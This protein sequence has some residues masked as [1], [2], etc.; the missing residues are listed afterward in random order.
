MAKDNDELPQPL[1]LSGPDVILLKRLEHA[2][3]GNPCNV[4]NADG[5]QHDNW[6]NEVVQ[7]IQEEV[8][9]S[10]QEAV[11]EIHPRDPFRG[12]QPDSESSRRRSPPQVEVHDGDQ[13]DC[14][15]ECR[16]GDAHNGNGSGEP[17]DP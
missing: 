8:H 3:T 6:Q 12:S 17:I 16:Y 5:G 10:M 4:P 11:Y 2:R 9:P 14:E 15:P 1:R 7:R 13:E